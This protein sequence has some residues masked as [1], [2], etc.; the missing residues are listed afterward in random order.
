MQ[1]VIVREQ[2][3][4]R[5]RGHVAQSGGECRGADGTL[6]FT[7]QHVGIDLQQR[8]AGAS[9][10]FGVEPAYIERAAGIGAVGYKREAAHLDTACGIV[11]IGALCLC[12]N[13][14][15]ERICRICSQQIERV[16]CQAVDVAVYGEMCVSVFVAALDIEPEGGVGVI[17][18]KVG[19]EST[20]VQRRAEGHVGIG[21]GVK[22]G[23]GYVQLCVGLR[24]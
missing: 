22:C 15:A 8:M 9:R 3:R 2:R 6:D 10:E 19:H 17:A 12:S 1:P 23:I 11:G 18:A 20:V 13:L 24:I 14:S 16:R 5:V 21:V 4:Q 7:A